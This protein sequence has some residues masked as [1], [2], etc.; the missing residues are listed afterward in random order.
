MRNSVGKALHF[1]IL[2][3]GRLPALA[4]VLVGELVQGKSNGLLH[5][6]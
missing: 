1:R 3:Q 4:L 5:F 6:N 2:L